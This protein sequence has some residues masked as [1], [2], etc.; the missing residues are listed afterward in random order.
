M[1]NLIRNDDMSGLTLEQTRRF[2]E[3]HMNQSEEDAKDFA[4]WCRTENATG[5]QRTPIEDATT[6]TN[7]EHRHSNGVAHR[8]PEP[9]LEP[10]SADSEVPDDFS[11]FVCLTDEWLEA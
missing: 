1:S 2:I 3:L 10:P 7:G 9:T 4:D 11:D 6:R 8:E 5:R